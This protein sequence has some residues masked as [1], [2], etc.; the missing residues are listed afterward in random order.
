MKKKNGEFGFDDEW[1]CVR[2]VFSECTQDLWVPTVLEEKRNGYFIDIGCSVPWLWNNTALLEVKYGW[3]GLAIDFKIKDNVHVEESLERG[4]PTDWSERDKSIVI[5]ESALDIDYVSLFQEH[6]VP[7]IIDFLSIDIWPPESNLAV[8]KKLPHKKYKFR[9]I[10]FEHDD[11]SMYAGW[12]QETISEITSLGYK[13]IQQDS[14]D[15]YYVL[16]EMKDSE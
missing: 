16:D 7:E 3:S 6:D 1:P 10:C 15:D 4:I 8:W 14:Q 13:H 11:H 2:G 12:R 5:E 9:A